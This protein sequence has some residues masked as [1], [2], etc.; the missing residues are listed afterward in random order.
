MQ[1]PVERRRGEAWSLLGFGGLIL[2]NATF[3]VVITARLALASVADRGEDA[4]ASRWAL[5]EGAFAL[6]GTSLAIALLGLSIAGLRSGLIARWHAG[7]GL[8]E[9]GLL[10]ASATLAAV[11]VGGGLGLLGLTG[12][13]LWVA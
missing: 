12:W 2:Q 10:V 6:N 9:A 5:H 11:V 7:L 1:W 8:V 4:V 13:L 3:A